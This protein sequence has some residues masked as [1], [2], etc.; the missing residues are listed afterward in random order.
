MQSTISIE[1]HRSRL[2]DALLIA[3]HAVAAICLAWIALP[4]PFRAVVFGFIALSLWRSLRR[5]IFSHLLLA[6][7]NVSQLRVTQSGGRL[8]DAI[9]LPETVVFPFLIALHLRDAGNGQRL[10]TLLLP[11]QMKTEEYR[12]VRV[13][14]R[15]RI[16]DDATRCVG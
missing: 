5:P 15:W 13:W 4:G 2:L 9:I 6:D 1:L 8:V 16:T 11:D 7:S 3:A 14:L 12:R 10:Y